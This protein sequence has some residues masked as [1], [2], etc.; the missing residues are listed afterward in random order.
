MNSCKNCNKVTASPK[1]CSRSC[2][3]SY[4]NRLNPKRKPESKCECGKPIK[5]GR[6]YC[7]VCNTAGQDMKLRQAIYEYHH[8]SSAFALV[9][10]RAR[11]IAKCLNWSICS[12]CGYDK[13]V[14]I[15]HRKPI[16]SYPKDTLISE[17][18]NPKN[19]IALCPNCHWEFDNNMISV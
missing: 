7:K 3:V 13:H 14:E 12:I 1:F 16:A 10:G 9:R 6:K 19:L 5:S 8:K 18:N 11:S 17:I 2:S 15:A 4:N